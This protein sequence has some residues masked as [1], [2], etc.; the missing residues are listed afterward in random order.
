MADP[1]TIVALRGRTLRAAA[2]DGGRS[3]CRSKRSA[4][5]GRLRHGPYDARVVADGLA[6]A[7][8]FTGHRRFCLPLEPGCSS[9][10]PTSPPTRTPVA[11]RTRSS[12]VP[13]A[14]AGEPSWFGAGARWCSATAPARGE[15]VAVN[16]VGA[17][18][19]RATGLVLL[20]RRHAARPGPGR[21]GGDRLAARG[22]QRRDPP[23][24][25]RPTPPP[26]LAGA[27]L[28]RAG[29]AVL[30]ADLVARRHACSRG[31]SP[32]ACTSPARCPTCAPPVPDCSVIAQRR[33]RPAAIRSGAAPTCRA[34]ASPGAAAGAVARQPRPAFRSLDVARRPARERGGRAL[35]I[36]RGPARV[37]GSPDPGGRARRRVRRAARARRGSLRLRVP[38]QLRGASAR[39]RA[40][41]SAA[42]RLR[43]RLRAPG[44]ATHRLPAAW[45][46]VKACLTR[47]Q[48][49]DPER[50]LDAADP[51]RGSPTCRTATVSLLES[52]AVAG[53]PQR[54]VPVSTL[55][56][57]RRVTEPSWR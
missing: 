29:R 19:G 6:V 4:A 50:S 17:R 9:Q 56:E 32:T 2:P 1:G 23:V 24:R 20:R 5:T 34:P 36:S 54:P 48:M 14:T 22:G 35:R 45:C 11:S 31:P 51:V 30:V 39:W 26:A 8:W 55:D 25:R 52:S 49:I 38:L 27:A 46:V 53:R 47:G 10:D 3:A 40:R 12:S 15:T 42:L 16:R 57:D 7:Y 37:D 43:V 13:C 33:L 21:H 41:R 28:R 44:R 18:R